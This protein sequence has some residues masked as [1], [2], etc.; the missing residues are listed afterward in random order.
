MSQL[1]ILSQV[2]PILAIWTGSDGIGE[3]E[4]SVFADVNRAAMLE[5]G[6]AGCPAGE[7]DARQTERSTSA[8]A[9]DVEDAIGSVSAGRSE[10]S[11]AN[12]GL[13]SACADHGDVLVNVQIALIA[14]ACPSD[15]Q[16]IGAGRHK[17]VG[18]RR[19]LVSFK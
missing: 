9:R 6:V 4:R 11:C 3:I 15:R 2:C 19:N 16:R 18:L 8:T 14:G 13:A 10:P 5:C 17:N 12:D 1:R 7:R